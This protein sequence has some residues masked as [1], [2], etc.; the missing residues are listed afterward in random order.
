[1]MEW[2]DMN[3][4]YYRFQCHVFAEFDPEQPARAIVNFVNKVMMNSGGTATGGR[5]SKAEIV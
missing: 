5:R 4:V 2:E 1:M 3:N